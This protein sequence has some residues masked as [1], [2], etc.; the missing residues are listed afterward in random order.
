MSLNVLSLFSGIGGLELGLERA[1]MTTVGQVEIDPF[2][3]RVLAKNWPEVP[4]HDDVRTAVEWWRNGARPT[5]DVVCGGFPCQDVSDAGDLA[6]IEGEQSGLWAYY[7]ET[8]Q[9]VRPRYVLVENVPGLLARG[10]GRVVGDLAAIGYDAEWDCLPAAA[11][12]APHL[13]ARMW[14]LAYPT[15]ERG[16]PRNPDETIFAGRRPVDVG[17]QWA[18]EP[19]VA[20]VADGPLSRLDRLRLGAIGNAVVPQVAE[21]IGQLIV[22][23]H[24]R[25]AVSA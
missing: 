19:D 5:V 14:I 8:I 17:T 4:R 21:Y 6:G 9:H 23:H 11:F 18:P 15:A 7:A 13:R 20:R 22:D 25:S 24:N 1:G 10:F 16:F 12:G 3:Q 2:C